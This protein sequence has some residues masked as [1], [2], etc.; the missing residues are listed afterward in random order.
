MAERGVTEL[1]AAWSAGDPRAQQ[2]LMPHVYEQLRQIAARHLARERPDHTLQAT[3][4]VHEAFE[5]LMGTDTIAWQG[6]VH[7]MATAAQLMRRILVDHARARGTAKRGA[8]LRVSFDADRE[9]APPARDVDLVRL[10]AALEQLAVLA[11]LQARIVELRYFG[12]L[13][14][15]ETAA[16]IDR[17]PATVKREWSVARAFLRRELAA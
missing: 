1:L 5:R 4:L 10:D 8:G 9:P 12:G 11:P 17:S 14:F 13:T 16:A 3:A 2:E 7:F 15:E 6:R